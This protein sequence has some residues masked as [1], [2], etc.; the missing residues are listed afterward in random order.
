MN[1]RTVFSVLFNVYSYFGIYFATA[2][3][4]HTWSVVTLP[5]G[6]ADF[7]YWVLVFGIYV[8]LMWVRLRLS[9]K[10]EKRKR[11]WRDLLIR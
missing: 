11:R 8:V 10:P 3:V 2:F 6:N 9:L 1:P 7:G 4:L 5:L